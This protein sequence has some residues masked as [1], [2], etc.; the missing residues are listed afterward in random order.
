MKALLPLLALAA[1]LLSGCFAPAPADRLG[2]N[3][4]AQVLVTGRALDGTELLPE[5]P[6]IV[7]NDTLQAGPL[8]IRLRQEVNGRPMG[9]AFVFAVHGAEYPGREVVPQ[10]LAPI[11]LERAYAI[12]D[13]NETERQVG[14]V[15]RD[16]PYKI[17]VVAADNSTV[18]IRSE[19]TDGLVEPAPQYGLDI[20]HEVRGGFSTRVLEPRAG[21]EFRVPAGD[22]NFE[23]GAYRAVGVQGGRV[24][25]EYNAFPDQ[26]VRYTARVLGEAAGGGVATDG[27]YIARGFKAET[28][29]TVDDGHGHV[30]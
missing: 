20:R 27:N 4:S 26:T 1:L 8:A 16:T 12:N 21:A 2:A 19:I 29:A 15:L 25:Y 11:Q 18:T 5:A 17:H 13:F 7:G 6:F 30:H 3:D 24:V 28:N 9:Q 10:R 23:P 22:P 14:H